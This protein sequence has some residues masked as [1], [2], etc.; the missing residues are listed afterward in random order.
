MTRIRTWLG[1]LTAALV[2]GAATIGG[3]APIP[4]EAQTNCTVPASDLPMDMGSP[5]GEQA[6]WDHWNNT[7]LST[8]P[9]LTYSADLARAGAWFARDMATNNYVAPTQ[10][11][12]PHPDS[13]G[14]TLAQRAAD[15]GFSGTLVEEQVQTGTGLEYHYQVWSLMNANALT[16]PEHTHGA[17]VKVNVPGSQRGNYWVLIYGKAGTAPTPTNTPVPPTATFTPV[18]PT[19]TPVLPTATLVPPT[20]TPPSNLHCVVLQWYG[21]N[22]FDAHC[23]PV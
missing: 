19:S 14:R 4:V 12:V 8:V 20:P 13:L 23:D 18:P 7:R 9:A 22:R 1:G 10:Y 3:P 17:V 15:C 5:F 6:M 16:R 11:N 21:A 2:L